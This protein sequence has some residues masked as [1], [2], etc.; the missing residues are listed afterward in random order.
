MTVLIVA[1]LGGRTKA[2]WAEWVKS[3]VE[4]GEGYKTPKD[5]VDPFAQGPR[6]GAVTS[7]GIAREGQEEE[8]EEEEGGDEGG[9][10]LDLPAIQ[11]ALRAQGYGVKVVEE[12]EE[13]PKA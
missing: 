3:R 10:K 1:L 6:G 5:E 8:S 7:H 11:E 9:A 4:S 12:K 2:E 13:V